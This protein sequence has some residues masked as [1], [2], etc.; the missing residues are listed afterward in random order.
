MED[1]E[2][3]RAEDRAL[4]RRAGAD[5]F[6]RAQDALLPWEIPEACDPLPSPPPLPPTPVTD[7]PVS[8]PWE[9]DRLS[10]KST[11]S[12]VDHHDEELPGWLT[13]EGP[14]VVPPRGKEDLL[15]LAALEVLAATELERGPEDATNEVETPPPTLWG[16]LHAEPRTQSF[17]PE[18]TVIRISLPVLHAPA[19]NFSSP[20]RDG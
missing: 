4:P 19:A 17:D 13:T 1:R 11:P 5:E 6:L 2:A 8:L 9:P 12:P 15:S 3:I 14:E 16:P 18:A 7:P 20:P 10:E